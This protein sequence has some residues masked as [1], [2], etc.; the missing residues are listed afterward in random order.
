MTL[1][2]D[3]LLLCCLYH[4]IPKRSHL[5]YTVSHLHA[6]RGSSN[7]TST[8]A[9]G[10]RSSAQTQRRPTDLTH[11]ISVAERNDLIALASEISEKMLK[12]ITGVFDSPSIPLQELPNVDNHFHCMS[13]ALQNHRRRQQQEYSKTKQ[14]IGK[15]WPPRAQ[16]YPCDTV[17]L[18]KV[19]SSTPQLGELQKEAV[20]FFRKWQTATMQKL[21]DITVS[22]APV[23]VAQISETHRGRSVRGSAR[24]R[25]G[26]R[27]ITTPRIAVEQETLSIA[28]GMSN[29]YLVI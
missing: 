7:P 28:T 22:P 9:R 12:D 20:A 10:S 18:T 26:R 17:S 19:Q 8:M 24:G 14:A 21:R 25:G 27:E 13:L 15:G 3:L 5:L 23:N 11:I 29:F 2:L 6:N 1:L 16:N 4:I